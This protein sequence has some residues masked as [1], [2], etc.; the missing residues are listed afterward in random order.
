M[1]HKTW[2]NVRKSRW[3]SSYSLLL[4]FVVGWNDDGKFGRDPLHYTWLLLQWEKAVLCVV[5][6][7]SHGLTSE[8][9]N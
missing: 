4:V 5:G 6:G 3:M 8:E 9:S 2:G 1:N 7:R